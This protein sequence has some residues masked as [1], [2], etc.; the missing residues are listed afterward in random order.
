[1]PKFHVIVTDPIGGDASALRAPIEAA[2]GALLTPEDGALLDLVPQADAIIANLV[3]ITAELLGNAGRCRIVA[4]LGVGVD[5]VDVLAATRH[6]IWVTNVPNYCSDEV[7]EHALALILG[8]QRR[9]RRSQQDLEN[10]TWNQLAYRGIHR[11]ADTTLG[12]VGLGQ[13][14]RATAR[15]ALGVGYRVVGHDPAI[16]EPDAVPGVRVLGLDDLLAGSDIVSLHLPLLNATRHLID[17]TRIALMKPGA[18]LINVSRGGLVDERAL[19]AAL[20]EGYL[21]GAGL[22]SFEEEPLPSNSSLHGRPD[23]MLTPHIAFLSE[24]ALVSLQRQAADEVVRVASG[25]R[26]LN[27]VN[28]VTRREAI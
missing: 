15:K 7:A 19:L 12:I 8:L 11:A 13:L 2:G 18:I 20:E 10:G 25:Q 22:D 9:L 4:R 16:S 1:M 5:S 17:A 23:V 3:P 6:G 27:P 24:E 28:E 26:P 21:G 14:G